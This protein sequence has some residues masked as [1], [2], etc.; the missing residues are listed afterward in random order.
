MGEVLLSY[1]PPRASS[2]S[3]SETGTYSGGDPDDMEV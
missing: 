1:Q 3:E 2:D